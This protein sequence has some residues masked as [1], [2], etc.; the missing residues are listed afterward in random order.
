MSSTAGGKSL[1]G[2]IPAGYPHPPRGKDGRPRRARDIFGHM[3][4][5][6]MTP[7]LLTVACVVC[8][9]A[10]AAL[11]GPGA[12]A[13]RKADAAKIVSALSLVPKA[14]TSW[15]KTAKEQQAKE[16]QAREQRAK[17]ERKACARPAA[18]PPVGLKLTEPPGCA[19]PVTVPAAAPTPVRTVTPRPGETVAPP[20]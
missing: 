15:D 17:A 14:V 8:A 1:D 18:V 11:P 19:A 2:R 7:I 20:G 6:A 10:I 9:A 16:R 13:N 3:R 12:N 4:P 5:R